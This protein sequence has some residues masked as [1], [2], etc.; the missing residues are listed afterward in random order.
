MNFFIF[1]FILSIIRFLQV[2]CVVLDLGSVLIFI[3]KF[4]PFG[5]FPPLRTVCWMGW[6]E[7]DLYSIYRSRDSA[8]V[9]VSHRFDCLLRVWMCEIRI[10]RENIPR[11]QSIHVPIYV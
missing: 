7:C 2:R 1:I 10:Y 4:N 5:L 3:S 11:K 6:R 9:S 8:Y